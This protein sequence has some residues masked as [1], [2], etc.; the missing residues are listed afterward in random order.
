MKPHCLVRTGVLVALVIPILLLSAVA[1]AANVKI[2]FINSEEVLEGYTGT[3]SILEG[4]NR[5]VDVWTQEAAARKRELDRAG[6]ELTS[7]APMLSDDKRRE[8]EQDYQRRL[9]EYDQFVRNIWGTDGL[10]VRRNEE[11]LRPIAARVQTILARIGADEGYDLILDAAGGTILY[12][13]QAIDLTKRLIDE[14]NAEEA[15]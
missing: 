6:R 12:A 4:F 8:M 1:A 7:Q 2:G 3:R 10:V 9:T 14:L 13:D 5:D 15:P 11:I